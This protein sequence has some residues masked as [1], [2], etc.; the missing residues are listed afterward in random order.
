MIVFS[1]A[2]IDGSI[3]EGSSG[4][5]EVMP[6]LSAFELSE[7]ASVSEVSGEVSES[8][9]LE[10]SGSD[11][12]SEAASEETFGSE[13]EGSEDPSGS[14][15]EGSDASGTSELS[16]VSEESVASD[17]PEEL[18]S[19]GSPGVSDE[20][21]SVIAATI[22]EEVSWV[23]SSI[24]FARTMPVV[25]IRLATTRS[26]PTARRNPLL[27]RPL[28][29][30]TQIADSIAFKERLFFIGRLLSLYGRKEE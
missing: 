8:P 20:G 30:D 1:F 19:E 21:S 3:R 28:V 26:I 2:I 15:M 14:V 7:G 25:V 4:S 18:S 10:S 22:P 13:S 24:S 9:S 16:E 29:I 12:V 17:D 5:G 11:S 6:S 23:S 27:R